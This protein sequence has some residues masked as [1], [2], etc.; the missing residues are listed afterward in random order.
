MAQENEDGQ[1]KSE[2]PT[3]KKFEEARKEGQV[4]RSKELST[5]LLLLFG[6]MSILIFG[7]WVADAAIQMM[8]FNFSIDREAVT[9]TSMMAIH[10]KNSA[11][12]ALQV[13]LPILFALFLSGI[14]SQIAVGGWNWSGKAIAPKGSRM[15]PV[16]GIK[17]IFSKNSVV[18]L[19]KATAKLFLVGGTA[20]GI[21]LSLKND[22]TALGFMAPEQAM[23][24][25]AYMVLWAFVAISACLI[26]VVLI[27]VPWQ[28]HQHK[29]QLKMTKQEVKDEN[30][31]TEGNPE[32]KSRIRRLQYEMAQ[33]R[34]MADV[35][36]ADVVITNPQHY[37]VALQ[38][39]EQGNSA[40]LMLAKGA[41]EIAFKIR[42]IAQHHDIPTL[43]L[44][45]LTRALY[46]TT[47][48]GDEIPQALYMAVAQVLAYVYQLR[49]AKAG[50]V[51]RPSH[52]P[53]IEV[54]EDFR[55]DA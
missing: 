1:E 34:M 18:E 48:I 14:L 19:G 23:A 43:E 2:E 30:K 41:D 13:I 9:S 47:E 39:D 17:R 3:S 29:E 20:V 8:R 27:D 12:I 24:R 5:F 51:K 49:Q 55:Y 42:E 15:N 11:I 46:H 54:P 28:L 22:F 4:A 6:G 26:A 40:P 37:A 31:N 32:I 21:V 50:R 25:G 7:A 36:K 33:R 35:P 38:Y 44:P 52:L 16:K 10:L 45:P 53:D